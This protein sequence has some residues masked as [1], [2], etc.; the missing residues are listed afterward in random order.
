MMGRLRLLL[1]RRFLKY[2]VNRRL[3]DSSTITLKLHAELSG[4]GTRPGLE[5]E[6]RNPPFEVG[7]LIIIVLLSSFSG[8]RF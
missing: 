5:G 4:Y 3:A 1:R 6:L 2:R 7:R 8:G